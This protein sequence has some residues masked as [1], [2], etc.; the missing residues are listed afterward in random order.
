MTLSNVNASDGLWHEISVRRYGNQVQVYF[1]HAEGVY[2]DEVLPVESFRHLV[3]SDTRQTYAG[4]ESYY[5]KW[6]DND[7]TITSVLIN[8]KWLS[9]DFVM[10]IR[11]AS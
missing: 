9:C 4:A 6:H 8:S 3:V 7:P 2:F 1:D 11:V 5:R 10:F